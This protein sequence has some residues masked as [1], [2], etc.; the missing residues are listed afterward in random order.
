MILVFVLACWLGWLV[1]RARVQREVVA[2]VLRAGGRV[3][4]DWQWRYGRGESPRKIPAPRWLV[5][6]VGIDVFSS[7]SG[8]NF[9]GKAGADEVAVQV[10]RLGQV[11]GVTFNG[12]NL[13]DAG[14]AHLGGLDVKML[15]LEGT[16]VTDDGLRHVR[17][18][19]RLERL[20]LYSAPVGDAGMAHLVGLP[21]LRWLSLG[22]TK[23]TDLGVESIEKIHGLKTLHLFGTKVGDAGAARLKS[24]VALKDLSLDR[25]R[26]SIPALTDL[27]AALPKATITPAKIA[28]PAS[29]PGRGG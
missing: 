20:D 12:S 23:V 5:D 17:G 4:Y 7:V 2:A 19:S 18:M 11:D 28:P 26:V 27:R 8:V 25:T 10:A 1:H 16:K 14:L 22:Q 6:A 13:T 3:E 9:F 21:G 24:L 29:L 15:H